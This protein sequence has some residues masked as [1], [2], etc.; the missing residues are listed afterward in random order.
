MKPKSEAEVE[1]DPAH[2]ELPALLQTP[3]E[4]ATIE[5]DLSQPSDEDYPDGGFTAWMTVLA[6]FIAHFVLFGIVYSFGVYNAHYLDMGVGSPFEVAL[7]GSASTVFIPGLGII[8]GKLS[9]NYGYQR[10]IL[11]G[12]L[13]LSG[14]IFLASFTKSL[15][16]LVLTQGCL[17]GIGSSIV[18][19]PAL[20]LPSQWF[21]KRRALAIGICASGTGLGGM[22]FS[23]LSDHLLNTIGLEW[24]LRTTSIIA[25]VLLLAVNPFF[26]TRI[27]PSTSKIDFSVCKDARFLLLMAACMLSNFAMFVSVDFLPIY[28][29][30]R[31][32]LTVSNGATLVGIYNISSTLGRILMGF[33]SDAFL[34]PLNS[35]VLSMVIT[36]IANFAWMACTDFPSLA[37]FSIFN[38]LFGGAV[39]GLLPVVIAGMFG[40][41]PQLVSLVAC[42]YSVLAVGNFF[43][44]ISTSAIVSSFGLFW[45]VVFAGSLATLGA[46]AATTSRFVHA[47]GLFSKV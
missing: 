14:G 26:K 2:P 11:L 38:G 9:A 29:R 39:W 30:D 27:P 36:A 6:G 22:A 23:M 21:K 4:L 44:P 45:M 42:L 18:Y 7:I 10:M 25:L 5:S 16:L 43:S 46:F 8:S 41:G 1:S 13:L 33:L 12:S 15:A 20:N 32:G 24:T 28:A 19:F 17:F 3:P 34:G 40:A 37:L 31:A 47:K 35:L